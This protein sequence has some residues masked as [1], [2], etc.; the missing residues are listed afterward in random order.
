MQ[1]NGQSSLELRILRSQPQLNDRRRRLV[2]AILENAE[3]S[4]FLSSRALARRHGVD[5]STIVRTVQAL[6]YGGFSG[7]AT[8]LRGHFLRALTPYSVL[9]AGASRHLDLRDRVRH[10]LHEDLER[11][12]TLQSGLSPDQVVGVARQIHRARRIVVVG[13]DLAASLSWFLAYGLT[14]LGFDAEAPTGSAGNLLH[15]VRFLTRTDLL[16]A[17]SFRKCLKETVDAAR[18]AHRNRVPTFGITDNGDGPLGRHCDRYLAVSIESSSITGSYV[19]PMATLNAILVACT[20]LKPKRSLAALRNTR[21]EYLSGARWFQEEPARP[22]SD[23]V[24]PVVASHRPRGRRR[25]V[26]GRP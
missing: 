6:G 10:S 4:C 20:H 14:A 12:R 15:H 19:A 24:Q 5:P 1:T 7:F 18:L 13:V 9:Q 17:I 11:L 21:E 2:Q 8:D 23:R 3:E 26:V 22:A 16:I 25:P